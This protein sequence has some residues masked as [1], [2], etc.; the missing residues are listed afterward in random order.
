MKVAMLLDNSFINDKRVYK[1][2]QTLVKNGFDVTVICKNEIDESLPKEEEI[3]GIKIKR[4]FKYNLGTTVLVEKNL[5]AH[6]DLI[7]NL[8]ESFDVYHCHDTETWPIGYLLSKRDGAKFICDSHEYFPDYICKEWH[9]SDLKYEL[10]KLLVRARGEYIKYCDG[11]IA[12]NEVISEKLCNEFSLKDKP[13]VIYNTR[14]INESLKKYNMGSEI[15]KK[16]NIS[17]YKKI[18]VF[19]G[20]VEP[21]RG[22]DLV[23]KSISYVE[24]CVFIIVGGDKFNYIEKL[25]KIVQQYNVKDKVVFTGKLNNQELFDY[26]FSAD[27]LIYL[28]L[29]TVKN[30]E[31][32]APNKFFDY[33]MAGK[34]MIISNLKFMSS[35]VTRY[36]I[37]EVID[38]KNIDFKEIG[39]KINSLIHSDEK[40][41]KYS[42]NV[43]K[44]QSLFSWEEQE[45]KLIDFYK[46][47]TNV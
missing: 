13:I 3:E 2:A 36:D 14:S 30:M 11:A 39:Y 32:S 46:K 7:N 28:G 29:S 20:T 45:K 4:L 37:G 10:T 38:I 43:L 44:I 19:S 41:C 6:F 9:T 42:K 25:Q 18:I 26:G 23:I 21:S 34:P 15:R 16:H 33:I 5:L 24:N 8:S 47:I 40:L 35:V 1:E 22:V 31:Y 17:Q 27:L 12:V